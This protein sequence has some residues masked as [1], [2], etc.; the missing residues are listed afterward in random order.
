MTGLKGIGVIAGG[1]EVQTSMSLHVTNK[2]YR[3]GRV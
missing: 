3:D 2:F 1:E